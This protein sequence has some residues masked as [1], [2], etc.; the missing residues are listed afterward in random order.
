MAVISLNCCAKMRTEAPS[1]TALAASVTITSCP[2]V[3]TAV[4]PVKGVN[5]PGGKPVAVS[6]AGKAGQCAVGPGAGGRPTP[7]SI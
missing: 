3:Q 5:V 7:A 4:A 2:A 1:G 6:G